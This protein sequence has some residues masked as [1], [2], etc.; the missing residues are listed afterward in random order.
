M[1]CAAV[2]KYSLITIKRAACQAVL[3]YQVVEELQR[4]GTAPSLV[5]QLCCHPVGSVECSF[6]KWPLSPKAT[7]IYR[8][9]D[10]CCSIPS[11]R[12]IMYQQYFISLYRCYLANE[13]NVYN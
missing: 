13:L 7:A 2:D 8:V 11:S 10:C 3:H 5:G 4:T 12:Y 1:T 6:N 9:V